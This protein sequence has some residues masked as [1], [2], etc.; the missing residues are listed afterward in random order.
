ML[1]SGDRRQG[2]KISFSR[3]TLTVRGVD[4]EFFHM[5]WLICD[6]NNIDA[7]GCEL[8]ERHPIP[9]A[10]FDHQISDVL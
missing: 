7:D 10:G 3:T 9:R 8:R 5:A 1:D 6:A 4:S 2:F